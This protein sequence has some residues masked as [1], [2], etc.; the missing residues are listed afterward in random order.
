MSAKDRLIHALTELRKDQKAG[1]RPDG[2]ELVSATRAIA[3]ATA[4]KFSGAI[5]AHDVHQGILEWILL[6]LRNPASAVIDIASMLPTAAYRMAFRAAVKDRG[7]APF[8]EEKY[9]GGEDPAAIYDYVNRL[10][11]TNRALDLLK[12]RQPKH[13]WALVWFEDGYSDE[14]IARKFSEIGIDPGKNVREWRLRGKLFLKRQL[15]GP[16]ER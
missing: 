5:D 9:P 11:P 6:K 14:E 2:A 3:H 8:D 16:D 12:K 13:Y 15:G 7:A 1:R 4:R 10:E